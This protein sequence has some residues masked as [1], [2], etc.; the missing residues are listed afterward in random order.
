MLKRSEILR[1]AKL[2]AEG[3]PVDVFAAFSHGDVGVKTKE[4]ADAEAVLGHHQVDHLLAGGVKASIPS[5]RGESV[6][7]G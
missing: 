4:V 5:V 2:E 1:L 6:V 3:V 7:E